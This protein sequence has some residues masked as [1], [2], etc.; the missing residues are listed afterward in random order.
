MFKKHLSHELFEK[1]KK[2]DFM[3][4]Y[5]SKH[6]QSNTFYLKDLFA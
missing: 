2:K 3:A 6:S 1:K 4:D 5:I